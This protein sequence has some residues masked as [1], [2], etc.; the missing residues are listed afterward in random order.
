MNITEF[1][2]NNK[3][4]DDY[5]E[6]NFKWNKE[7]YWQYKLEVK[8]NMQQYFI[9]QYFNKGKHKSKDAIFF[10]TEVT[11]VDNFIMNLMFKENNI[12]VKLKNE[13]DWSNHNR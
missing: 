2:K 3:F 10:L 9:N 1:S 4:V 7:L 8:N 6:S 13:Y 11:K 5:L 12:E